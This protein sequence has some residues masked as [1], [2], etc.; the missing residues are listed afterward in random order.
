M[1]K[2]L[3]AKQQKIF[4]DKLKQV[5]AEGRGEVKLVIRGHKVKYIISESSKNVGPEDQRRPF[6]E[7]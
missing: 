3:D 4:D 2:I 5:V 6:K 7:L 1:I